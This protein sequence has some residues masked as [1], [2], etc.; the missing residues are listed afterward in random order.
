MDVNNHYRHLVFILG[1][2]PRGSLD[3]ESP[4]IGIRSPF[5][6]NLGI[7]IDI[8]RFRREFGAIFMPIPLAIK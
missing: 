6:E 2:L 1:T 8:V 7:R 4:D 5:G 3:G